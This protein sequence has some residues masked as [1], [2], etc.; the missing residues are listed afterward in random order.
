MPVVLMR[1][2][3]LPFELRPLAA[4]DGHALSRALKQVPHD[5][6]TFFQGLQSGMGLYDYLDWIAA[7][8]SGTNLRAHEVPTSLR[9]AFF[10]GELIGRY[11]L[12]HRLTPAL[13]AYA[14]HVGYAVLPAYR[15]MGV[16]SAML[17]HAA[18]SAT[19]EHGIAPLIVTCDED[20]LASQAVIE[21]CGGRFIGTYTGPWSARTKKR[22]RLSD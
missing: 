6:P 17:R 4:H 9:F 10:G 22:Y 8:E 20:N 18:D 13:E 12:R 3:P 16:A 5:N 2:K 11:S 15:R 19:R 1:A 7:R 14:G 21:T